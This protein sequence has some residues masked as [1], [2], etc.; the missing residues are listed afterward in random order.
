MAWIP[1]GVAVPE[2]HGSEPFVLEARELRGK[3]SNGMI[4]SLRE[5]ALGDE[6]DG[7]LEIDPNDVGDELALPGT[8]FKE[9]YGLDDVV[10]DCENKMFTHRPDCF[11]TMGIAREV[12][13]IFGDQYTSPEWYTEPLQNAKEAELALSTKN[14]IPDL[15]PRFTI[16]AVS[17][18]Q[19]K[20]SPMWLQ[21]YLARID[22]KSINNIVDYTNFFMMETG[23]PLHAFDYDKVKAKCDGNVS[24]F[25]RMAN[26][27]EKLALLNGKYY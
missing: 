19:V 12:A 26:K 16:Q 11:G 22:S 3:V 17:D 27:G 9:L 10:I 6:H 24:I 21:S 15:V 18:I 20:Q 4:A 25:P 2:T 23:Q 5:L 7:I 13:G 8:P 1:P 14:D